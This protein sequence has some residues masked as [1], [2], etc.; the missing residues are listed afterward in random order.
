MSPVQYDPFGEPVAQAAVDDRTGA[1]SRIALRAGIGMFW[2]MVAVIVAARAA[3][4]DPAF[5]EKF[6]AVASL[7]EPIKAIIGA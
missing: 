1:V 4:F 2:V 5:A 3:Y 7:L 6:A